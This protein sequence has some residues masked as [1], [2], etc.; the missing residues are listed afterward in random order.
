MRAK[1]AAHHRDWQ[2][3]ADRMNLSGQRDKRQLGVTAK[4]IALQQLAELKRTGGKRT[5]VYEARAS[6][7]SSNSNPN[8][9]PNPNPPCLR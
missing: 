6:L 4:Q 7:Y 2:D 9:N 5:Q 1:P 8:L 3:K